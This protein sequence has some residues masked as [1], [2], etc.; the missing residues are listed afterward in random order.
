MNT[1]EMRHF[2]SRFSVKTNFLQLYYPQKSSRVVFDL[3]K[4]KRHRDEEPQIFF[5]NVRNRDGS[6]MFTEARKY[7][8]KTFVQELKL[9][10]QRISKRTSKE[11]Q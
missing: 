3:K 7:L 10:M 9:N 5:K 11:Q 4:W 1:V 8:L 6:Q 2:A